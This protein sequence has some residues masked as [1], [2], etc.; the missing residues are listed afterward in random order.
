MASGGPILGFKGCFVVA[1]TLF[2]KYLPT[3]AQEEHYSQ[4][5]C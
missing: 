3:L 4:L 1:I 5:A 2:D